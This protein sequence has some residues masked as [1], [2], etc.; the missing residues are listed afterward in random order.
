[1]SDESFPE[2]NSA[3]PSHSTPAPSQL[4]AF[5]TD[6]AS[7]VSHSVV[8]MHRELRQCLAAILAGGHVLLEGPP[9][10]AKT[11]LVRSIATALGG[12]YRRIQFTPD[13]MPSDVTGSSIFR[14]G[15]GEFRFQAGPIF[16]NFVL[17]DEINRAPAKTQAALLEAMGEQMV[18]VDGVTH[19]LPRPFLVFATQ[20]PLEHEGTYPLPEA[21]L[22][23][24]LFKVLV[25]YPS[26]SVETQLLGDVHGRSLT[27][28][29]AELGVG[30]VTDPAQLVDLMSEVT[31]VQVREDLPAYVVRLLR[32]TRETAQLA[33][34]A[35]PRAGVMLLRA[36]KSIAAM[37]G[38]D[39]VTPDDVKE[40]F[41]PAMRHRVL[42]DPAEEIEGATSDQ[43]LGR[44]L[45]SV[46]VPR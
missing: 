23:R 28:G 44:I 9:G 18:T 41:L 31:A 27:A 17:C 6:V 35:S 10:V 45:D 38:R 5:A 36:A 15:E 43:V 3:G 46:E 11:F 25:D 42:L 1:M 29:P 4:G 12:S 37:D 32:A 8:G 16:A 2:A 26:E 19:D 22:D 24:F 40:V 7:E 20:N 13:L 30:C 21:Q 33:L 14:P 34:G 39:Y